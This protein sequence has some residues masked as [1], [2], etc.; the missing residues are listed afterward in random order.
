MKIIKRNLDLLFLM[1]KNWFC[2]M[3]HKIFLRLIRNSILS[4]ILKFLVLKWLERDIII[5]YTMIY[6]NREVRLMI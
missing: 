3:V 1:N 2:L 6:I 5:I 4:T